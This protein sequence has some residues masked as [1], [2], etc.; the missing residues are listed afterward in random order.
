[1]SNKEKRNHMAVSKKDNKLEA[2]FGIE[3]IFAKITMQYQYVIY[4][5]GKICDLIFLCE[6][7]KNVQYPIDFFLSEDFLKKLNL[8]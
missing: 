5:T 6:K 2:T 8:V 7:K 1:M 3:I 4:L